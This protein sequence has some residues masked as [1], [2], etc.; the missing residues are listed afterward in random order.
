VVGVL[1]TLET[2]IEFHHLTA[3][4]PVSAWITRITWQIPGARQGKGG[5][6]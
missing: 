2:V 3:L 5:A 6:V 4:V 1:A